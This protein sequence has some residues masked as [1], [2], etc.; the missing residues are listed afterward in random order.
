MRRTVM[1]SMTIVMK[2]VTA[3]PF[4]LHQRIAL[5]D[6]VSIQFANRR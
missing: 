4:D 2:S 5:Y 6:Y 1:K 3:M